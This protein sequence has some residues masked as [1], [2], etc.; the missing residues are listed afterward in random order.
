MPTKTP[1]RIPDSLTHL[2]VTKATAATHA[3]VEAVTGKKIYIWEIFL[4]AAGAQT[5]KFASGATDL[6]AVLTMATASQINLQAVH[7]PRDRVT[8]TIPLFE[9]AAG[10]AF[11]MVLSGAVAVN[12]WITYSVEP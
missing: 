5:V 1:V 11:N 4:T 10:E 6:C 3:L 7:V 8:K 2:A 12:G 9:T